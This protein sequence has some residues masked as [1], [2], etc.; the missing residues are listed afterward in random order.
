MKFLN[1]GR[2]PVL[3]SHDMREHVGVIESAEIGADRKGRAQLRFGRSQRAEEIFQDVVDGIRGNISV[4]YVVRKMVLE[5]E[6]EEKGEVY[7]V[8]DWR[9]FEASLVPAPADEDAHVGRKAT[10]T[11]EFDTLIIDNRR[12]APA[13]E[14]NRMTPEEKAALEA[15]IRAD[16]QANA[17][18][19][20]ETARTDARTEARNATATILAIGD[21]HGLQTEARQAIVDG[22]SPEEFQRM[23]LDALA[24]RGLKPVD[25]SHNG[26]LGLSQRDTQK[27]S[28]LKLLRHLVDPGNIQLR[29]A[30]GFELECARAFT[31]VRKK[32]AQGVWVPPDAFKRDLNVGTATEGAEFVGTDLDASGFIELLRNR[33]VLKRAGA[34]VLGDLVGNLALPRQTGAATA[35]WVSEGNSPAESQQGTGLLTL[36][37]K[38]VGAYTEYTRRMMNQSSIDVENFVRMDLMAVLSLALDRSGLHGASGGPTGVAATVGVGSVAGGADGAQPTYNHVL[39][40][41]EDAAVANADE[42]T[43]AY[44]TN[45]KV[46]RIL[47]Q[48]MTNS[49]YGEIPLWGKGREKGMGEVN[50]YDAF[51][52]NQVAGDLDKGASTGVCSAIFYGA[53][54]QVI[55]GLWSGIDILVNPYALDTS[56]GVRVTAFQDADVAVRQ[57]GAFSIMLDALTP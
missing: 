48:T 31:D 36:S 8:V 10:T 5:E 15:Q 35:Y 20:L 18:R 32:D 28:V 39:Q 41:E 9:P 22:K 19:A 37:P 34:N 17:T 6:S 1:S 51:C 52:T 46:R 33:M 55:I 57:P 11:E 53:W 23:A 21:D 47:K 50:G 49:T 24:K 7:R 38:Q 54:S 45:P 43:L 14:D 16:E 56:G 13:V 26:E 2:A 30:A 42:M 40:L 29:E 44:I 27:Y 3:V 4:G 25:T 12:Q